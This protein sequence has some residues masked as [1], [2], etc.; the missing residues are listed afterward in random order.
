MSFHVD[1]LPWCDALSSRGQVSEFR[2][3]TTTTTALSYLGERTEGVDAVIETGVCS[4]LAALL[5][6]SSPTVIKSA[7]HAVGNIVAGSQVFCR[8]GGSMLLLIDGSFL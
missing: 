2:A 7:L 4:R 8:F 5:G 3:H 6:T 1:S